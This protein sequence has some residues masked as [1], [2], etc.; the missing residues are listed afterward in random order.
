MTGRMQ[1][2]HDWLLAQAVKCDDEAKRLEAEVVKLGPEA[3]ALRAAADALAAVLSPTPSEARRVKVI[4]SRD[5]SE[6]RLPPA[7]P[8]VPPPSAPVKAPVVTAPPV[9]TP[10]DEVE[11]DLQPTSYPKRAP[12]TAPG[13]LVCDQNFSGRCKGEVVAA[14]CN[15]KGCDRVYARCSY[16][17]GQHQA[18]ANLRGHTAHHSCKPNAKGPTKPRVEAIREASLRRVK[19]G[20]SK[21]DW[22]CRCGASVSTRDQATHLAVKHNLAQVTAKSPTVQA[23]WFRLATQVQ[24]PEADA[25]A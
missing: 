18:L 10:E 19:P 15:W 4:S 23:S 3:R 5:T 25:D 17:G 6:A 9:E 13:H 20:G 21:A 24:K 16:H 12:V 8:S 7:P 22:I 11:H 2:I 1:K 14:V